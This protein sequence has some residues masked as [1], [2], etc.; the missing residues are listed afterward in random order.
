M[1]VKKIYDS[2]FVW[3]TIL[4]VVMSTAAMGGLL[5]T[6]VDFGLQPVQAQPIKKTIHF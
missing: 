6:L 5:F 3:R 2:M 1:E 4:L